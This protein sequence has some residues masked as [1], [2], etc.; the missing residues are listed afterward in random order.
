MKAGDTYN[1]PD[2]K[3]NTFLKKESVM[4]GWEKKGEILCC[5]SCSKKVSDVKTEKNTNGKS[6]E[7]SKSSSL[8]AFLDIEKEEKPILSSSDDEKRFCRD[9]GHFIKHPFLTRCSL[10][11]KDVNPM[12]DCP[13]FTCVSNDEKTTEE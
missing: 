10:H 11:E 3:S 9:C 4:D 7:N 5:A 1:C 12:D 2:C 8:A 13:D 6:D